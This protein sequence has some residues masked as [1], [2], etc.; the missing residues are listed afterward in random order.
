MHQNFR[1]IESFSVI[2]QLCETRNCGQKFRLTYFSRSDYCEKKI[3][4]KNYAKKYHESDILPVRSKYYFLHNF[5]F[6]FVLPNLLEI[7]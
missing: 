6:F 3:E 7:I 1:K 4:K 2:Y 5:F